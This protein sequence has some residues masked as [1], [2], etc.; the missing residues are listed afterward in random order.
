MLD[1]VHAKARLL[2]LGANPG[3]GQPDR[4]HQVAKR[5]HGEHASVDAVGL[6]RQRRQALDLLGVGDQHLPAQLLEAVVHEA[7]AAHRLDHRP[8]P[9]AQPDPANEARQ[10]VAITRD[11]ELPDDLTLI[12]E[13]TNIDAFPAE[14]Q[15]SVQHMNGPPSARF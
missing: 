11:R 13:H 8:D 9:D 2:A 4:R 5:Q 14:I 6:A 15:P 10:T 12:A 7:R 1:Q 3:V